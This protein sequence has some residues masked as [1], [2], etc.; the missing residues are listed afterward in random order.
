MRDYV[1][2]F[3][4]A[5]P[6]REEQGYQWPRPQ[7]V[8]ADGYTMSV[9]A[10]RHHYCKPRA[11]NADRYMSVEVFYQDTDEPEGWVSVDLVN[12]QIACHGGLATD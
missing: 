3:F 6:P 1:H 2:E 8:C 7:I 5:N 11:N 9:Q 10:S 12:S 4:A